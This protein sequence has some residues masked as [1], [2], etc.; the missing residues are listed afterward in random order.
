MKKHQTQCR[1]VGFKFR[2]TTQTDSPFIITPFKA[3]TDPI[4]QGNDP[5]T[6]N[7]P[8]DNRDYLK[9]YTESKL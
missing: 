4:T 1:A 2:A 7:A 9:I 8:L 5:G 6:R 3:D